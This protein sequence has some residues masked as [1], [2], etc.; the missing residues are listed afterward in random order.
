MAFSLFASCSARRARLWT[1][2]PIAIDTALST[3]LKSTSG[4]R[5][6]QAATE[7][8]DANVHAAPVQEIC[9][10]AKLALVVV[11]DDEIAPVSLSLED[12]VG[13]IRAAL[14]GAT[15][16]LDRLREHLPGE[17]RIDTPSTEQLEET[18]PDDL[19]TVWDGTDEPEHGRIADSLREVLDLPP[20]ADAKLGALSAWFPGTTTLRLMEP[21]AWRIEAG[22]LVSASEAAAPALVLF[23]EDLRRA[24]DAALGEE[25]GVTLLR[26]ALALE[27]ADKVVFG[28]LSNRF[29]IEGEAKEWHRLRDEQDLPAGRYIPLSKDRLTDPPAFAHGL[30]LALIN[31]SAGRLREDVHGIV[32]DSADAAKN[33]L[34]TLTPWDFERIVLESS[35]DEGAWEVDTLF[36]LM[37]IIERKERRRQAHANRIALDESVGVIRALRQTAIE[38]VPASTG[39]VRELRREELYLDVTDVNDL[40]LPLEL[41]DIFERE[42]NKTAYMLL[43]PA[44]D[45]VL[46]SDGRRTLAAAPLVPIRS[47]SDSARVR[48]AAL[49]G[50]Y[51]EIPYYQAD[52]DDAYW[53]LDLRR[54]TTID[55]DVLD[56]ATYRTDGR[57][58]FD[59]ASTQADGLFAPQVARQQQITSR[60]TKLVEALD[61]LDIAL[62]NKDADLTKEVRDRLRRLV[63][64]GFTV[65]APSIAASPE[66]GGLAFGLRRAGRLLEPQAS[67]LLGAYHALQTRAAF[68]HDFARL[69]G[70]DELPPAGDA[71]T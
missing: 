44:C 57:C 64:G 23:D 8:S 10:R 59:G 12:I 20:P 66:T 18:W 31:R 67:A 52:D 33:R 11:V 21:S 70:T 2:Y 41:G 3:S 32:R 9:E 61:G 46:R 6:L 29:T 4:E 51:P 15:V 22:P 25:G 55:L 26:E 54:P 50:F 71:D 53:H 34:E 37:G 1:S 28:L 65:G 19:R 39:D 36:R 30:Q 60:F 68:E 49:A 7:G 35:E 17:V 38:M 58:F 42:E 69:H 56:L 43:A 5:A 62:R 63:A 40:R 24:T 14:A 27:G 48:K 47:A 45:L 13:S 16:T